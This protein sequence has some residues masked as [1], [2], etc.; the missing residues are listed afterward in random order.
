MAR[1]YLADY[2]GVTPVGSGTDAFFTELNRNRPMSDV[3]DFVCFSTNPQVHTFDN[4][5]LI[6]ALAVQGLTVE[7]AA[8]FSSKPVVVSPVTLR[9]RR[10]PNATS[11][12]TAPGELPPQVDPRQMSLFG[13]GWTLGSI[14]SLAQAGSQSVTY[15][16]TVGWRGVLERE[17]GSPVPDRFPSLPDAVFPLYHV[18]A[19]VGDFAGSEV[20][21]AEPSDALTVNALVLRQGEA[22]RILVA[23]HTPETQIV[24]LNGIGGTF[25][26]H[27]LDE[28]TALDALLNPERFRAQPGERISGNNSYMNLTM[29]PYA[30]CT[31]DR[32]ADE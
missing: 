28:T 20:L 32:A 18:L 6:E 21:R 14:K 12:Q 22:L 7:N 16:E 27:I 1:Q 26:Q 19:N 11:P 4:Q 10:N 5:S 25:A 2:G 23:N 13:A 3:I 9:I 15:Y 31:L 24:T 29:R 30:I 17:N 8:E